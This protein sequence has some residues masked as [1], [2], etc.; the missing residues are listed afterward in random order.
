MKPQEH[1]L[2]YR[3]HLSIH[4]ESH[5]VLHAEKI[6]FQGVTGDVYNIS[7]PFE[8]LGSR[9]ILGRIEARNSEISKVGFFRGE[10]ASW[11]HAPTIGDIVMFQDPSVQSVG[12]DI[13][14]GGTAIRTDSDGIGRITGW[15]TAFLKGKDI[16]TLS[17]FADAPAGMKDVRVI[18]YNDGIAVFTRPQGGL[19]GPGKIGFVMIDALESL[20]PS[21]IGRAT[22][23]DDHFVSGEW[24][25]AN[26]LFVLENGW[27]GVLGHISSRDR[28]GLLHYAAMTF[29]F[30]PLTHETR[31]LKMIAERRDFPD[32][33][34][35]R[36]DLT[37]V[38]FPGGLERH[39]D[40]TATLWAGVS[41]C[42]AHMAS[43]MDPFTDY[44]S[45]EE[46]TS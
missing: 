11:V 36:P 17:R 16:R 30:N 20:S 28:H 10:G 41:D 23:F 34:A 18:G 43:I 6:T 38:I 46:A 25:G 29:A 32:G 35:K 27:I 31:G 9:W 19:A 39:S 15:N 13:V 44:L 4:R 1:P 21:S 45:Y 33:P 7:A 5:R 24:G 26:M 40:G 12:G 37:D 42:E 2:S 3:D 8:S 22:V 14:I